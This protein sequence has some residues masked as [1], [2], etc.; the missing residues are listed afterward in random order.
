MAVSSP[1]ANHCIA[2]DFAFVS[3]EKLQ[4][5]LSVTGFVWRLSKSVTSGAKPEICQVFLAPP[6]CLHP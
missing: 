4:K 6:L 5:V 3:H 1:H 2:H